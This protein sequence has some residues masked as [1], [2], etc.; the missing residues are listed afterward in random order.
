M[1]SCCRIRHSPQDQSTQQAMGVA[2]MS[3]ATTPAVFMA[4]AL[5]DAMKKLTRSYE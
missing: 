4:G 5:E 2:R 3:T 1:R